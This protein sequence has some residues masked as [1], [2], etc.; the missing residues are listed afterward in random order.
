M[1]EN[2]FREIE[3]VVRRHPNGIG[4]QGIAREL[5]AE[6]PRRTLQYR[7]GRL[8][9]NR[10]LVREGHGRA[11]RYR[12]RHIDLEVHAQ[13]GPPKVNV[14]LEV[15]PGDLHRLRDELRQRYLTRPANRRTPVGYRREFLDNYEPNVSAY[16]SAEERTRLRDMGRLAQTS[17]PA[18]THA[19]RILDRML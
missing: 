1:L 14:R 6:L 9:D 2:E 17:E 15:V 18:G 19:R 7:L 4:V 16:L 3:A 13:A 11:T 12:V 5:N 10:R 8:V